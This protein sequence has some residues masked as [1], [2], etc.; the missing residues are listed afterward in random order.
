M[1]SE[2][3]SLCNLLRYIVVQESILMRKNRNVSITSIISLPKY[4]ANFWLNG[5]CNNTIDH[6]L[7]TTSKWMLATVTDSY[8][9]QIKYRWPYWVVQ[10]S[11]LCLFK[12]P[13][14]SPFKSTKI[15]HFIDTD[16]RVQVPQPCCCCKINSV[17]YHL[18]KWSI[19][20]SR[21]DLPCVSF[22]LAQD[23]IN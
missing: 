6:P 21:C 3:P 9:S 10:T 1:S 23:S 13:K 15:C 2:I 22:S 4:H 7:Y 20:Q 12:S 19:T 5:N 16:L 14:I 8:L 17:N 18:L 11:F